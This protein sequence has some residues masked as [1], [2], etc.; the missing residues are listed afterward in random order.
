MIPVK[1]NIPST[2]FSSVVLILILLNCGIF[3]YQ[4]TLTPGEQKQLVLS[5]GA[6]PENIFSG[7]GSHGLPAYL[8]LITSLFLHGGFLHLAGNMLFLW[9]F[10]DN[11][12]DRMGH[13]SFALFYLACGIAATLTHVW[14]NPGSSN[15][16]IGASGS[17]SGIL[18]AYF[19][20]FPKAR[21]Q[22]LVILIIFI[23]TIKVPAVVFIGGWAALQ[24][25][26]ISRGHPQIAWYAHAGG[27]ITGL[28]ITGAGHLKG[29]KDG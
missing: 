19:L 29:K 13:F 9:I 4:L 3:I 14:H 1:D 27:F 24:F 22:V 11:V 2:G 8:T 15:P 20:L 12:E 25:I 16:L 7:S 28:V 6:I 21:V 26:N 5:A 18:G 17:I 23:T 10:G